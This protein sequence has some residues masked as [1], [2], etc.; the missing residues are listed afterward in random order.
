MTSGKQLSNE[1]DSSLFEWTSITSEYLGRHLWAERVAA[2][3]TV[4]D[5]LPL[6]LA[7]SRIW[8]LAHFQWRHPYGGRHETE[9]ERVRPFCAGRSKSSGAFT[10]TDFLTS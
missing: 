6:K 4:E 3:L 2:V 8:I 10:L 5:V 7:L 1:F 9:R